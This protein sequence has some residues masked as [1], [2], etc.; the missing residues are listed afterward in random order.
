MISLLFLDLNTSPLY[1]CAI[2]L[3]TLEGALEGCD[4]KVNL[5]LIFLP[6][7]MEEPRK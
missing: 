7:L 6:D 3:S 4:G 2:T 1:V 5:R